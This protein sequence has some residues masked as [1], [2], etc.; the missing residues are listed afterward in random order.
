[1]NILDKLESKVVFYFFEQI[2]QIPRGSGNQKAISDYIVEFAKK[3]GL[4]FRQDEAYNV[5]ITKSGTNGFENIP[6]VIFQGHIDMVCKKGTQSKHDFLTEPL[7]LK[8]DGNYIHADNTTLGADNG[9]AVAYMLAILDSNQIEH[10]PIEAIFTTDEETGMLGAYAFDASDLKGK[11]LIN[12]DTD[13]EGKFII[14]C[15]GG[16]RATIQL[17]I[18]REKN[19]QENVAYVLEIGGL[20]GGHSGADIHLQRANA[21]KLLGRVL[22]E[23][24]NAFDLKVASI[25][26]GSVDNAISSNAEAVL[27]VKAKDIEKIQLILEEIQSTFKNEYQAVQEN[28]ITVSMR[29]L[30]EKVEK[31]FTNEITMKAIDILLLIPYGVITVSFDEKIKGLVESSNNIGVVETTDTHIIFLNAIRSAVVSKKQAI[32]KQIEVIGH[33]TGAK[34]IASSS[35]PAWELK[36]NSKIVSLF[37]TIYKELFGENPKIESIHAGLECGVFSEK[38]K[39]LDAISIGP[40]IIAEHTEREALDIAS[41]ERT[42]KLIKEVLKRL[43]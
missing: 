17:P 25:S 38:I 26:G 35:Y 1:M 33:L 37:E 24:Y 34:V 19:P 29:K 41:V 13:E 20:L 18:E 3:R 27:L 9:I 8:I 4:N 32:Y 28:S 14:S 22:Y 31:V 36:E 7:T 5:L 42:W 11:I 21:N 30:Q 15:S 23:I 43:R 16:Q 40:N 10:P 39:D 12:I 2:S 6:A